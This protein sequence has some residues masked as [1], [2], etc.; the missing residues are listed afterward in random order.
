MYN[1]GII[2]EFIAPRN[3]RPPSLYIAQTISATIRSRRSACFAL[4]RPKRRRAFAHDHGFCE[5]SKAGPRFF[6]GVFKTA[7]VSS[8]VYERRKRALH[9][10]TY[11]TAIK[12]AHIICDRHCRHT[13]S[14]ASALAAGVKRY[15]C[16]CVL[17][18]YCTSVYCTSRVRR[19]AQR[20]P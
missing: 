13:A 18:N 6:W 10:C 1:T 16:A 19:I 11:Q 9:H 15:L 5:T 20:K 17:Y 8:G 2:G 12:G 4:C 3:R 14:R 7:R